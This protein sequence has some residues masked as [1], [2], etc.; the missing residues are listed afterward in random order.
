MQTSKTQL[1]LEPVKSFNINRPNYRYEC[2]IIY[3]N[4]DLHE[5]YGVKMLLSIID[6]LSRMAMIYKLN[7]KKSDSII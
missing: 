5:A 7:D 1:R 3:L 2:D 4:N 6:V